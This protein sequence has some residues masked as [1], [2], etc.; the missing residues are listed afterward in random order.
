MGIV[1]M[2]ISKNPNIILQCY[3]FY[4]SKLFFIESSVF[5]TEFHACVQ[6]L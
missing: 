4:Y 5:R 3:N 1:K 6:L 2:M